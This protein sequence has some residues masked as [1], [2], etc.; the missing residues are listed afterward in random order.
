M[1]YAVSGKNE[2][3]ALRQFQS[4]ILDMVRGV[5]PDGDER[6]IKQFREKASDQDKR[7]LLALLDE[8]VAKL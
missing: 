5:A 3:D 1:R 7:D 6:S 4:Q 8:A 2:R